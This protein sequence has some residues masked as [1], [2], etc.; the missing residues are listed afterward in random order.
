[1]FG[2]TTIA[3]QA[4]EQ[5][6]PHFPCLIPRLYRYK[7]DMHQ[8]VYAQCLELESD[9]TV[10]DMPPVYNNQRALAFLTDSF[11]WCL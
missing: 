1:M 8:T 11:M 6:E 10:S 9:K 4:R 5:L 7:Y 2:M 3:A